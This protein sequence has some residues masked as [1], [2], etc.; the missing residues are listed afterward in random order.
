M[1][2][3][4]N[5]ELFKNAPIPKAVLKN[6]IPTMVVMLMMLIYNLADT[7]FIGQTGND[8][9]VA[10]VS[11]ATPVFLLFITVGTIFGVGGTS[12]ISRAIGEERYDHAK[13][14]SSFCI[15]TCIITG[16][17]LSAILFLL[18][19][20]LLTLIGA[21][22]ETI[23]PAKT[24]LSIIALCSPFILSS[25]CFANL[26]RAEGQPGKAVVGQMIGNISNIVLDPIMILRFNWGI[27]GAA[28]A[29]AVGNIVRTLFYASFF[30][31]GK[32]ILSIRPK[33]YTLKDGI[34]WSVIS[35]GAPASLGSLLMSVA[36]RSLLRRELIA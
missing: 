16:I 10:A 6:V 3:S 34:P 13:K 19:D 17:I 18:M 27:A 33:D 25:N 1:D 2:K 30:V 28:I 7:F 26:F 21:S 36:F 29:T 5:I 14:V 20:P 8:I 11:L 23:E 4:K 15:W 22:K 31:R 32:S 12:V 24:Y 35:I 9:L